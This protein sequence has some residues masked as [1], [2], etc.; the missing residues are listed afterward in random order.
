IQYGFVIFFGAS[1]PIAFLLAYFNNLHEIRLSANRLVWKHQRPI[2]KRVAGIGAWKTVLYFQTC[3]GITI[4]AMVIAFTSQ[5]VPRELYRARVDYNLR[6]YINSTL[7]VFATSDY[8]SVSKPFV[9][10]P[11]HIMEN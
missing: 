2:P 1:F 9:I 11:F 4:Q 8:S 5:F 6:G 10:K 3:I 7:S